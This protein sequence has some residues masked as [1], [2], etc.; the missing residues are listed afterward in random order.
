MLLTDPWAPAPN[1]DSVPTPLWVLGTDSLA[2]PW[3]TPVHQHHK[4]QLA[5]TARGISTCQTENDAWIVPM[6]CAVWI[7]AGVPHRNSGSGNV[8]VYYLYLDSERAAALPR[9]CCA[10]SV[11]ALLQELLRR[12]VLLPDTYNAGGPEERLANVILDELV[13]A[14]I[15]QLRLPMPRDARLRRIAERLIDDP[16]DKA[17]A[18]EWASR[19]GLSERTLGR[20]LQEETGM[21]FG[22]WRRQMRVLVGLR[23][24]E[25]GETI[26]TIAP[27]LGYESASSFTATFRKTLGKPP[28][29][30]LSDRQT[31]LGGI[32]SQASPPSARVGWTRAAR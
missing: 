7:P 25:A 30:Y 10:I 4:G 14:P 9:T 3:C 26:Q 24:L 17:T 8:E 13:S 18:E 31:T 27:R 28:A 11:S 19:V 23:L 21:G 15:E 12:A 29:R 16:S 5:F 32:G 1:P 2:D 20:L 22:S 6:Q